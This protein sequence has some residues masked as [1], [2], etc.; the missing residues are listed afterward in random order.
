MYAYP[1]AEVLIRNIDLPVQAPCSSLQLQG[2]SFH[3]NA[4]AHPVCSVQTTP[5]KTVRSLLCSGCR[6]HR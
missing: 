5:G 4:Y 1:S 3:S 6:A 2:V